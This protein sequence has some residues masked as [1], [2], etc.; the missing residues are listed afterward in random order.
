M[1][2]KYPTKLCSGAGR[3]VRR[4][5]GGAGGCKKC[6]S[7]GG[8]KERGVGRVVKSTHCSGDVRSVGWGW[9]GVV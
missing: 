2:A 6:T 8:S 9:G 7:F 5:W 1:I 3:G 4:G